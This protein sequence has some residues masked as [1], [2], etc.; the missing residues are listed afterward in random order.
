MDKQGLLQMIVGKEPDAITR[1]L[2]MMAYNPA[3]SRVLEKGGVDR[4]ADLMV[5][6]I[7]K[8]YGLPT[9]ERFDKIHSQTCDQ[10]C[11]TFKTSHNGT[12][13]YG[14]AQKPLN[15]FFKV[16]ID[17]SGQPTRELANA[18]RPFLHVPLDSLLMEFIAREFPGDYQ[19][20]IVPARERLATWIAGR[21]ENATPKMISRAW[22][23]EFSLTGIVTKEIYLSWQELLRELYPVKP[24]A[25]DIIWVLER[26]RIRASGKTVPT[27][28][29]QDQAISSSLPD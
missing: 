21:M 13:S 7:P 28:S 5:E 17:W 11:S 9:R 8:F 20:R 19:A 23:K 14:Q 18:L 4:F 12:P 16:Y 3:I 27:D 1:T 29:E 24:V 10:I 15:V 2:A 26:T 6:A 25:L 22:G